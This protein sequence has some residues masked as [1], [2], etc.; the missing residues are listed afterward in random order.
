ILLDATSGLYHGEDAPI[1]VPSTLRLSNI[2]HT[3]S[4]AASQRHTTQVLTPN[5]LPSRPFEPT[6]TWRSRN[7]A[8]NVNKPWRALSMICPSPAFPSQ[9]QG[10][11]SPLIPSPILC[12]I[13]ANQ[14][15]TPSQ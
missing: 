7:K 14:R 11:P 9:R 1:F 10:H 5:A 3:D 12:C 13:H 6:R 8:A 4:A 15:A 2:S